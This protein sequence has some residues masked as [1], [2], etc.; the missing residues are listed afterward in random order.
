MPLSGER[1]D[2]FIKRA[3]RC[4]YQGSD[5]SIKILPRE[6]CLYQ[7]RRARC[8][9]PAVRA[10]DI[11]RWS[12]ST[13]QDPDLAPAERHARRHQLLAGVMPEA[14]APLSKVARVCRILGDQMDAL[15][16]FWASLASSGGVHSVPVN[17]DF[18]PMHAWPADPTGV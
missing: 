15:A 9:A 2:A 7:V 3:I 17:G 12:G 5:A 14:Y 11:G 1:Y 13:A 18:S 4:L 16:S 8:S 10:I 6:R